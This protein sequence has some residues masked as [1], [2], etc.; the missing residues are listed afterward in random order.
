MTARLGLIAR[1]DHR[2]LGV[3]TYELW[4]HLQPAKTMVVRMGRAT[5]FREHTEQYPD[6]LVA[7]FD[8]RTGRLPDAAMDWLTTDV[9]V[10]L[11][12]ETPYDH[13]L[14]D[15]ARSRGVGTIMHANPEFYRHETDRALTRPDVI[16]NP[17]TWR[18]DHMPGVHHF[19]HPVARDRFH[20]RH[21]TQ[22]TTFLHVVGHRG[23]SDRAGT[24]LVI[25]ALRHIR[26]PI[27]VLIRSQA[28]LPPVS[29]RGRPGGAKVEVVVRDMPEYWGMY[30]D[31]DVLLAPRR[32][33]GQS[34]PVNEA[35][36]SGMP[37]LAL[38]RDPE[39]TWPGVW[40]IPA[41]PTKHLRTHAGPIDWYDASPRELAGAIDHLATHPEIVADLST[42][43]DAH[44]ETIS[45][46][47][48][49]PRWHRMIEAAAAH[50]AIHAG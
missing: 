14:W 34:L 32:F 42:A 12:A 47:T 41:A 50:G 30:R 29:I 26:Q 39:R 45:W 6:A 7:D 35:M 2:G 36:A 38:D 10:I 23:P 4:R 22:A 5:P 16:L 44:A 48:M 15:L 17:T 25:E 37:V 43:A 33:G 9:D 8:S 46:D 18:L 28:P 1:A 13:R 19:P 20:V 11:T 31:G 21:V 40:T 49:L 27:R 24:M 3:Q